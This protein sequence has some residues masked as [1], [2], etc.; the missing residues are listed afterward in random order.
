ML[1]DCRIQST[2]LLSLFQNSECHLDGTHCEI[3]SC[4]LL[5]VMFVFKKIA[6]YKKQFM[7]IKLFFKLGKAVMKIYYMNVFGI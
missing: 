7:G 6:D 4:I 5:S 1:V 2:E 3:I